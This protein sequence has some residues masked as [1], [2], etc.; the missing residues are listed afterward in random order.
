MGSNVFNI[1]L[2]I[3]LTAFLNPIAYSISYNRD[4][5]IFLGGMIALAIIPFIGEKNKI[6]RLGGMGYVLSYL[7]Y[8]ASIVFS[9]LL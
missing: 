1:V 3:G 6:S 7:S 9:N 2:I 4:I 5:I 8:M